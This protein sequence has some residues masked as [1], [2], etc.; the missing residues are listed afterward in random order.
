M[1]RQAVT[2][3]Q[4]LITSKPVLED[5]SIVIPT[6]GRPILEQSL[7]RIAS[8]SA[9]P[10]KLIIVDQGARPEVADWVGQLRSAGLMAEHVPSSQR[11]RAAGVNRG[12]ERFETQFV[13]ITDDDCFVDS[14]WL[15][16]L[17]NCLRKSPVAIVTGRVEAAGENTQI[18][19]TS[20][21][22]QIYRRPRLKFD[23]MS[24]GNM[25][26]ARA[27]IE[28]VGLFDEDLRLRTAEDA[29]W[30]YRALR[31]EIPII[32]DPAVSVQH[33]GWRDQSGRAD[34]YRG[35]ARSH[36]GFYGKYIR[37]GDLFILVRAAVHHYRALRWWAR[38]KLS[39]NVEL[40]LQGRAYF[41]G[42]LPGMIAGFRAG[43]QT[44]ISV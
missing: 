40:A 8:G 36:G 34:Q 38:G 28:R 19:V 10:G 35:Y 11:G 23:A 32:Y 12:L 26:T 33:Y 42:L 43:K 25:G 37:K 31:N 15:A 20:T 24:G 13:A 5:I 6:L 3:S 44:G 39:G 29:E 21:T 22:P 4:S 2:L 7:F 41:T 14:N 27:V 1:D 30:S 18:V 9:W 16:N 17:T